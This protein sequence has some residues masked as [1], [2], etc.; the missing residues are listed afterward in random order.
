MNPS[1]AE[2]LTDREIDHE[3]RS[4]GE[5]YEGA[6]YPHTFYPPHSLIE[7]IRSLQERIKELERDDT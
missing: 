7:T 2:T 1:K 5:Y 3:E 4:L 6:P